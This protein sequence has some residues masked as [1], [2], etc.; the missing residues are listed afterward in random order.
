MSAMAYC[1]EYPHPALTTDIVV[2]QIEDRM[3][4]VLLIKRGQD[5]HKGKWALPGG[6]VDIDEE[7]D[8]CAKRELEEETGISGMYL[9]QLY[10]FGAPQRDPRERIVSVAYFAV[11]RGTANARAA[12]DAAQAKWFDLS[13]LPRLAF[14]HRTIVNMA[15]ERLVAKLQYST[16]ALQ[17]L[18]PKFSLGEIQ[19]VYETI[20]NDNLD[21]RNF[22]KGWLSKDCL[23]ETAEV[24]KEGN[25]RPAKL[26]RAKQ[27]AKVLFLK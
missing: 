22:R 19:I 6:F 14:D 11:L 24:R 3:L 12:S 23:E 13:R 9:E 20:L 16:I 5:P 27:P 25:H 10:T 21:K 18:A 17:F 2:F 1:Y 7:L 8:A 15:H 26:Y 4:K